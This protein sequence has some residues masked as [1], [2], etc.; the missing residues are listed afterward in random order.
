MEATA[1]EVESERE[2]LAKVSSQPTEKAIDD[3]FI[4]CKDSSSTT[5]RGPSVILYD[6]VVKAVELDRLV[7]AKCIYYKGG[8]RPF[9]P[10]RIC[11]NSE[12]AL[13]SPKEIGS[14]W[15]I[16]ET[17]ALVQFISL[18]KKPHNTY[19]HA[20]LEKDKDIIP[21]DKPL[22]NT[23]KQT[24]MLDFI[25]TRPKKHAGNKREWNTDNIDNMYEVLASKFNNTD[26][27]YIK[28]QIMTVANSFLEKA[29][30]TPP[31]IS[32][33]TGSPVR[34][35]K[36]NSPKKSATKSKSMDDDDD[37]DIV[38]LATKLNSNPIETLAAG[39]WIAYFH[40]IF[41]EHTVYT[42]I[43]EVIPSDNKRPLILENGDLIAMTDSIRKCQP[44]NDTGDECIKDSGHY[45]E[46]RRY[47]LQ[48]SKAENIVVLGTKLKL[49]ADGL[50]D[51]EIANFT[52]KKGTKGKKNQASSTPTDS[53]SQVTTNSPLSPQKR[54]GSNSGSESQCSSQSRSKKSR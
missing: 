22:D 19:E 42:R 48:K 18:T 39:D 13:L 1:A 35:P 49:I 10:A 5:A 15:P 51:K 44:A 25:E 41:R 12:G 52:E 32:L 38:A 33:S 16:P 14:E 28:E 20:L 46:L 24:S 43:K 34:S 26:A 54:R 53:D 50:S 31:S 4:A 17:K 21:F 8:G 30:P 11:D 40:H 29:I 7:W 9:F 45:D 23:K 37:C 47:K 6:T 2:Q 3:G 36:K 27:K